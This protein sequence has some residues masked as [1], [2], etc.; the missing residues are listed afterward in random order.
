MKNAQIVDDSTAVATWPVDVWFSGRRT[1]DAVLQFGRRKIDRIVLDPHCR[2]PDRNVD[3]NTWPR[4]P[5][6]AE[7]ASGQGGGRFG[8]PVCKG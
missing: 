5:A 8:L 6:P 2:F 4:Q 1:F 3:D 7:P